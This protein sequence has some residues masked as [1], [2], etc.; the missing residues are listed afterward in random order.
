MKPFSR[1]FSLLVLS[2]VVT[3]GTA[4]ADLAEESASFDVMRRRPIAA[5]LTGDGNRLCVANRKS[6]SVTLI[7]P[8]THSVLGEQ[9]LGTRLSDVAR[10]DDR[11]LLIVDEQEH[12][13]IV[14]DFEG[15]LLAVRRRIPV[16]RHPADLAIT[17]DGRTAAVAGLW[18]RRLSLVSWTPSEIDSESTTREVDLS[19]APS[20]ATIRL[21]FAPR[22]Q[23]F[24][25]DGR[26]LV[27][28]D[29][30][31]GR[32]ALINCRTHEVE[33]IRELPAQNIR[34]MTVSADEQ[35]L[36][37]THQI[38]SPLARAD[39]DDIH[40][41]N[42]LRNVL[43]ETDLDAV[44]DPEADLVAASRVV[45][46]GDLGNGAADPAGITLLP[47]LDGWLACLAGVGEVS[48]GTRFGGG[49]FAVGTLP[50]SA[51][52]DAEREVAYVLCT[53]DDSIAVIDPVA[54]T[55]VERISLGPQPPQTPADRGE[56]LFTDGRRSH[57]GWISCQ[58]CHPDGHT[59]GGLADTTSDDSFGT[60]KRI[61]SLLG[62]R[63]N[64]PW[65]WNGQF[66]ELH[67]Q[68]GSSFKTTLNGDPLSAPQISDVV[69]Y[70][71]TLTPPPP[72]ED[73]YSPA[74][75]DRMLA[76]RKLFASLGCRE[77]HVPP[78]TFTVDRTFDVGIHDEAGLKKFNPPSLRGLSQRERFFHDASVDSLDDVFTDVGHQLDRSL[79][80]S[81]LTALLAY[82]RS[83]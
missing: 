26:R 56:R 34:G 65:A 35:K 64:N 72:V 39:F 12:Q 18:S 70:L 66:K 59:T 5:V 16:A 13:L 62:T 69:A 11:T 78:Q 20:V 43:R 17:A 40:W 55:V 37:V 77:C 3:T 73:E 82:L 63:D 42:L 80:E 8:E 41:G 24:L 31:G 4:V 19:S 14:A 48:L 22:L 1:R 50:T 61:L 67:E 28:A 25:D 36:L 44:L 54:Q 10:I 81:E 68:V 32:I 58:S 74:E 52:W 15:D 76:G 6:G 49:R 29:A 46:L 2:L 23:Q 33:S 38:L 45:Q 60:P 57:D 83:L 71:H 27:V 53:L 30:F 21:P 79:S 51:V 47:E 7:D 75:R 9:S